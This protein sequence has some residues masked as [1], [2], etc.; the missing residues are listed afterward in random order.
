MLKISDILELEV[1]K[2]FNLIAGKNGLN[3]S[4]EDTG[5]L[6]Y[7]ITEE[8]IDKTFSKNHFIVTSLFFAKEDVKISEIVIKKLLDK[9]ISGLAVKNIFFDD[10]SD[11]I[12]QYADEKAIPI[13]IFT[14]AY[15]DDIIMTIK[16][17]LK[18]NKRYRFYEEKINALTQQVNY[19]R[20]VLK[21][22]KEMNM[23]FSNNIICA[24]CAEKEYEN[25]SMIHS[26][27]EISSLRSNN[28]VSNLI[29]K[30]KKG[31]LIIYSYDIENQFFINKTLD[32][33]IKSIGIQEEKFYIAVSNT[34]NNLNELDICI[35][36]SIYT[37]SSCRNKNITYQRYNDIGIDNI[38]IPMQENK[39]VVEFCDN[40]IKLIKNYDDNYNS[41]LMITAIEYI[42]N[43]GD[44]IKT[45]KNLY[46][47]TNTTRYRLKKI[48]EIICYNNEDDFYEKLFYAIKLHL[49]IEKMD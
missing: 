25:N 21:V 8:L 31:I 39:Y 17:A 37:L 27:L 36:E 2:E 16:N 42:N 44:I 43:N 45:A 20:E 7:E 24:Y 4:I 28:I 15:F 12:K 49:I 14:D 19:K 38:L 13:F 3:N 35:K 32:K 10:L 47:H 6:E 48:K 30:Y 11:N 1:F 34:H 33:Y 29:I 41:N 46:Q 23:S 5:I 22:A 18:T 40:L 9:K 26:I